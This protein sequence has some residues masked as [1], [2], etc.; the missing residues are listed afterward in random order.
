M[1]EEMVCV[2]QDYHKRYCALLWALSG[3]LLTLG[4]VSCLVRRNLYLHQ[5]VLFKTYREVTEAFC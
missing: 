1:A 4:E 3:R 2:S 5:A